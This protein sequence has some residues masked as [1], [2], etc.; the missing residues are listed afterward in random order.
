MLYK[1]ADRSMYEWSNM[2]K[3]INMQKDLQINKWACKGTDKQ[4]VWR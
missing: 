4:N 1:H 3:P 2:P